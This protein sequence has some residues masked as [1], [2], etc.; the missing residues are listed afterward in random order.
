[1]LSKILCL[2]LQEPFMLFMK[3]KLYIEHDNELCANKLNAN[4]LCG[5]QFNYL[6]HA[7]GH[8]KRS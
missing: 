4:V 5:R 6:D 1:M 2:K 3:Y 7:C 8:L